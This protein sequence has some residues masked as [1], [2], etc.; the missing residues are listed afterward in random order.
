C[1][2][3]RSPLRSEQILPDF[4]A[5]AEVALFGKPE[6]SV[7]AVITPTGN[8]AQVS[9]LNRVTESGSPAFLKSLHAMFAGASSMSWHSPLMRTPYNHSRSNGRSPCC[10][11]SAQQACHSN[12]YR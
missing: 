4:A 7:F 12:K 8:F 9:L 5:Y 3:V 6:Q 1:W 10:R 2:G 11:R